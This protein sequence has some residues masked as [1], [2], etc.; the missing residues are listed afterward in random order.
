MIFALL[1]AYSKSFQCLTKFPT[2]QFLTKRKVSL[3]AK[4]FD[5]PQNSFQTG[6]A[7]IADK[8][9]AESSESFDI[10]TGTTVIPVN[11]AHMDNITNS[12]AKNIVD[13]LNDIFTRNHI[14]VSFKLNNIMK[15]MNTTQISS[16]DD[17]V[18]NLIYE[19]YATK[20]RNVLTV[21]SVNSKKDDQ[22]VEGWT[23]MPMEGNY[24]D[25]I[26]IN[27]NV[28]TQ[29][30]EE[31]AM[32]LAHEGGHWLGL[33]HTF[34]GG[35]KKGPGDY[36][37]D[38]PQEDNKARQP[39]AAGETKSFEWSCN[40][41]VSTCKNGNIDLTNNIMDYTDC[42]SSYTQGQIYRM[43]NFV[44]YRFMGRFP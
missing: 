40:Q 4:Y 36:V 41:K 37:R 35:C 22:Y 39:N 33:Y 7:A 13:H 23:V 3:V 34:E 6:I 9:K 1:L 27:D 16:D 14:P 25:G 24:T 20:E 30:D 32:I 31:I 42:K 11:W 8:M 29:T 21:F 38:T 17:E 28:I 26:F 5:P 18:Q 2:S 10:G 12:R 43:M 44:Y 19:E 15:I